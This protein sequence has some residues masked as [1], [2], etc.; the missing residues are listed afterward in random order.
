M[1][2][3]SATCLKSALEKLLAKIGLSFK[4]VRGQCYDG[5]SNMRGEFNG[6]KAKILEEN[7]SAYYVHCFAHQLQLV[8]VAISKKNE[9]IADFFYMISLLFNVV[10]A[11]CKRKDMIRESNRENVKESIS[12]GRI[13]TGTGLNQD[14]SLQ[15]AGDTRWGSH[16]RTLSSL[17]QLFPSIVSVLNYVAKEGK[18]DSKKSEARGLLS[19]F[20][21][22]D[23][24]FYLHMMFHILGSANTL[25][26]ALQQ[27][28]Q[29]I[30]NAMSCVK[31]TRNDLQ[32][33]R[34]D[35]W[36]SLLEKTMSERTK[37]LP[38]WMALPILLKYW[39]KLKSILLFLWCI[40]FSSWC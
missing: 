28:D 7:R 26:H 38:I 33:L 2:E 25:S 22:F 21:T 11:F 20:G 4:Q 6:L 30:L 34:D 8:I 27:K 13:S 5:A 35:G 14:Q 1:S 19:Y 24:V 9:D 23:F 31:S 17:I 12:S 40:N 15:R 10:G 37:D 18:K 39:W 16:Y 29:D 3:T 36:E 32:Q